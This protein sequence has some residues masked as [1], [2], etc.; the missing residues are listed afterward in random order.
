VREVALG[1]YAHQDM[2]FDKL[3][4]LLNPARRRDRTPLFQVK[5]ILHNTPMPASA[6]GELELSPIGVESCVARFDLTLSMIESKEGLIGGC[7]YDTE[8]FDA[9]TIARLMNQLSALLEEIIVNPEQR[10]SSFRLLTEAESGG[11]SPSD[12]PEAEMSQM[13]FE[14]LIK[15]ITLKSRDL[16]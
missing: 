10:L 2:P 14:N 12:F 16:S 11:L 8:L 1:A 13:D 5:L 7:E 15:E 3:V 6:A 4:E 9:A